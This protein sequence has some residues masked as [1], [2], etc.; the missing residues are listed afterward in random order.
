[1]SGADALARCRDDVLSGTPPVLYPVGKGLESVQVGPGLV[2]LLGGAPGAGKTALAVQ[3][4]VDALRATNTLRGVVCNVEMSPQVLLERQLARL[5]GIDLSVIRHRKLGEEHGDRMAKAF[6]T[7]EPLCERLCFVRPPFDLANVAA[8]ADAFGADLLLLDYLQ[9][10]KPP[11]DHNDKR[12]SVD[13]L[14]DF[15]RQFADAGRAIIAVAAVGRTKDSRGRSSYDANGLGLA[16][17]KETG[18]IE[19]GADSAYLL[20]PDRGGG[21]GVALRCL[22]DRYG[23]PRDV[24]LEFGRATQRF[25]VSKWTTAP[26]KGPMAVARA[27]WAKTPPAKESNQ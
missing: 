3:W 17:F 1:V 2:T 24:A 26:E 25:T 14:M 27:A 15:L 9:R 12:G 21:D 4:V 16:S 22:K 8:A 19:Y 23:E 18:E 10:I 6:A 20:C 11:G 13:A 7:L 5:S